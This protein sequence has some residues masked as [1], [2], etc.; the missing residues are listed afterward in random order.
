MP[1]LKQLRVVYT[2]M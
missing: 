2:I 1:W